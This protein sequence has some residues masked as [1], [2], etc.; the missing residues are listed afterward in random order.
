MEV[1]NKLSTEGHPKEI[2]AED[3]MS[4]YAVTVKEGAGGAFLKKRERQ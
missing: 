2:K 4:S 3:I 1:E